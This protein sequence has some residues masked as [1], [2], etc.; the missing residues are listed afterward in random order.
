[1][2]C[3]ISYSNQYLHTFTQFPNHQCLKD[4]VECIDVDQQASLICINFYGLIYGDVYRAE[5]EQFSS[6]LVRK[7][8]MRFVNCAKIMKLGCS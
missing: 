2:E 3:A 6:K 8:I 4:F 7:F 1:M 5:E